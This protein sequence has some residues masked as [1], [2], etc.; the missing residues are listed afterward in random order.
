MDTRIYFKKYIVKYYNFFLFRIVN[1]KELFLLQVSVRHL[2]DD[3]G[4]MKTNRDERWR[5]VYTMP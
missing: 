4:S 3:C 1:L 2:F 5:W